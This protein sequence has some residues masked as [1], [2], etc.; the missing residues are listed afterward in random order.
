M[1]DSIIFFLFQWHIS[2]FYSS[3]FAKF[4]LA[5]IYHEIF[6]QYTERKL[7]TC[8]IFVLIIELQM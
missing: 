8:A 6:K 1:N 7:D 3:D 2:S 4:R 5:R